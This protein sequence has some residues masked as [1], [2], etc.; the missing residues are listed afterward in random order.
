MTAA[1]D[2]NKDGVLDEKEFAVMSE[3]LVMCT[4]LERLVRLA[5]DVGVDLSGPFGCAD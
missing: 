1:L 4:A 5:E 3:V 2:K